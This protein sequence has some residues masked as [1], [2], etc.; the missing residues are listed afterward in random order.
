MKTGDLFYL[1]EGSYSDYNIAGHFK[2]LQDFNLGELADEYQSTTKERWGPDA[3][4]FAAFLTRRGLVE[5]LEILE[6][7]CG[8]FDFMTEI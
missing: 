2:V 4:G 7:Y 5:D 3:Q 1:S 6:I 8:D